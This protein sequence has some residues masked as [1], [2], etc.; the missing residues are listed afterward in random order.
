MFD[1]TTAALIR[2]APSLRD[3]INDSARYRFQYR[4]GVPVAAA[5][6]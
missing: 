2:E 5:A 4:H 3:P 6:R 1:A